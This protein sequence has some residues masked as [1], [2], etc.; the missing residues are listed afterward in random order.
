MRIAVTYDNSNGTVWQHFGKT[1]NFKVYEVEDNKVVSSQV[2]GTDG[3]GHGALAGVLNDIGA[4]VVIC[5]GLGSPVADMIKSNGMKLVP[6][7]QGNAD[8]VV[9][10]YLVGELQE[11]AEAVHDGCHHADE[12]EEPCGSSCG[13]SCGGC[14]GGCHSMPMLEGPNAGKTV[15][16]HYTGTL[17]NGDK[18]DSS[19]DRGEPLEFV[20]GAGMMIKGFD[21]AVVDMKV[22]E[23]KDIHL[24]PEEAYG[25]PDPAAI[26]KLEMS[27]LPGCES[28]MV[29]ETTYLQ[30]QFGQTFPAVV[31]DKDEE[32]IVFDLNHELAGKELNFKIKLVEIL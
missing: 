10:S 5:G 27:M 24:M 8:E 4:D 31:V 12:V 14:G 32:N 6:G 23:I 1:E 13:G 17:N 25:M 29:G 30:N 11:D 18:F 2:V 22:G 3:Q 19:F 16:V 9:S 28:L 26:I 15:R 7:V 21:A 20:C